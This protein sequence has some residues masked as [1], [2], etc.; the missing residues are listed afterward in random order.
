MQYYIQAGKAIMEIYHSG[1]YHTEIKQNESPLT[2]ADKKSHEIITRHLCKTNLPVLSEEGIYIDFSERKRW[3][4]FWII[5]PLDGT[6]EFLNKINGLLLIWLW[7]N[8][9]LR[10]AA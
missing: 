3:E 10:L 1:E 6:K 2:T 4:Y 7:Y 9:I 5:D 8:E